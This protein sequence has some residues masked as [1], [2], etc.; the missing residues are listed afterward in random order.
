MTYLLI[1]NCELPL[2]L[3]IRLG[4]LVQLLDGIIIQ[5]HLRKLDISLGILMTWKDLRVVWKSCKRLVQGFV[6][7]LGRTF[8][9]AATAADEHGIS[10]ENCAILA[11]LKE[12]TDAILSVTWRVERSDVDRAN[13]EFGLVAGCFCN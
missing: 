7:L 8:K 3:L 12:E 2:R 9:K 1:T 6:H 4:V 11:I 13:V 5:Y 10:G